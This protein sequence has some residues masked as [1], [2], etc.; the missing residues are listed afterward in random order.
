MPSE[1]GQKYRWLVDFARYVKMFCCSTLILMDIKIFANLGVSL[2]CQILLDVR[3]KRDI[4]LLNIKK[5]QVV[6]FLIP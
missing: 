2:V 5:R 6:Q 4:L 3:M 1:I